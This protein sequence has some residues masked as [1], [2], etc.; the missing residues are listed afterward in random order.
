MRISDWSSDVCS[1]DLMVSDAARVEGGRFMHFWFLEAEPDAELWARLFA[2]EADRVAATGLGK[3]EF[4]SPFIPTLPGTDK[5]IDQLCS[6]RSTLL[7]SDEAAGQS[8]RRFAAAIRPRSRTDAAIIAVG[9]LP[10][11]F[12]TRRAV[13]L[14][15]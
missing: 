5:Y 2:D 3:L 9:A 12:A 1:S 15:P 14:P 4:A 6:G 7:P 13:A 11:T 10:H 8:S